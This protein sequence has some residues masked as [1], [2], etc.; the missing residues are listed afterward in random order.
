MRIRRDR[1][2]PRRSRRATRPVAEA[3]LPQPGFPIPRPFAVG[4]VATIRYPPAPSS[5]SPLGCTRKRAS[6]PRAVNF[7]DT[8]MPAPARRSSSDRSMAR[9]TGLAIIV[10][11]AALACQGMTRAEPM[12]ALQLDASLTIRGLTTVE[13]HLLARALADDDDLLLLSRPQANR[14]LFLSAVGRKAT[15]ALQHAG[16]EAARAT[17]SVESGST[18]ERIVVDVVEGPRT[19]AAGLEISGLPDELAGGLQRW[20]QGQ[21]PP[22]GSIAETVEG[23]NGWGGVRW[24]DENGRA[25]TMEPPL[26]TRGEPAPFDPPHL[27]QIR[28]AIGRFLRDQGR[29]GA[30][31]LAEERK[32]NG[33]LAGLSNLAASVRAPTPGH[34]AAAVDVAVRSGPGGAVLAIGV[35]N[36]PPPAVLRDVRLPAGTRT[37]KADLLAALDIT[38]GGT[39]TEHDRLAW[40]QRL[41]MSG[42]FLEAEVSFEPASGPAED[43]AGFIAVFDLE[44]YASAGALGT[45]LSREEEVMLR[46]RGW[47]VETLSGGEDLIATWQV[48]PPAGEGVTVGQPTGEVIL[49]A[50][51]GLLL[52]VLPGGDEA[53]GVSVTAD[54][55]GFLLPAGAGRFEIPLPARGRLTTQISLALAA[56][57]DGQAGYQ[58][59]LTVGAGYESRPRAT[60]APIVLTARIEP[61]ACLG[62][63]HEGSARTRWEGQT[64]IV[65]SADLEARFD[66]PTGRLLS[67]QPSDG[68]RM[69]FRTAPAGLSATLATLRAAAGE[70][71]AL[72]DALI[73]SGIDFF[74]APGTAAAIDRTV[75]AS[76]L[77]AGRRDARERFEHLVGWF[78]DTSGAREGG[79]IGPIVDGAT[80]M[81][82]TLPDRLARLVDI[83]RRV[84]AAGGFSRAD[85]LVVEAVDAAESE[86]P[87]TIPKEKGSDSEP[88]MAVG[89]IAATTI[90]RAI[91]D[92]GCRE[93]WPAVL[94]RLAALGAARDP[95]TLEELA[96][97]M[98]SEQ[99]GP[100]A[101]L[102]AANGVPIPL[103][104]ASLA[105]RGQEKLSPAA[106]HADCAPLLQLLRSRGFDHSLVVALRSLTD[107]DA[108]LVGEMVIGDRG[109]LLP[110][111]H[112]LHAKPT[113]AA[114]AAALPESLDRWWESALGKVVTHAL[115]ERVS[116]RTASKAEDLEPVR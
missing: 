80:A 74:T 32:P 85:A 102:T 96:T 18:G 63:V 39:V 24:V 100:L 59:Q 11:A 86:S 49:S 47:L 90:W 48:K 71:K 44:D 50:N 35:T 92:I 115:H 28:T 116:P 95:A 88:L 36:L 114:A 67:V 6:D 93:S 73:T 55:V 26:W 16:F 34:L 5:P 64:L 4:A 91:E 76:G 27:K 82:T 56:N 113:A 60:A 1:Q 98:Q 101:Y 7:W 51:D 30:A 108:R 43:A 78:S 8:A 72:S 33:L 62:I 109:F 31:A 9:S 46:F 61:S 79:K 37:T 107:D 19:L 29:F 10:V 58:R 83:L 57:T 66:G 45:A 94:A 99:A 75:A 105:R 41:R 2:Y 70:D 12:G 112:D 111:V 65:T 17:A 54:G 15:L 89:R 38:L 13:P 23:A 87:L 104:A 68:V 40:K 42:R 84:G 21:R 14:R 22:Q 77:A 110:L 103:M 97:F 53:C 81:E 106:F 69:T 52:S 25:V 3:P 20:L